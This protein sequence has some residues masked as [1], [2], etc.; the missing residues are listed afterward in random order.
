MAFV[1]LWRGFC[2]IVRRTRGASYTS[3]EWIVK[4]R[5]NSADFERSHSNGYGKKTAQFQQ[6]VGLKFSIKTA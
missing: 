3:C 6:H 5:A 1:V 4:L 2:I